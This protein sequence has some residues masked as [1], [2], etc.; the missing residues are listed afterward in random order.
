MADRGL[1]HAQFQSRPSE[2][3]VPGGGFERPQSI[4]GQVGLGHSDGL[5]FLMAQARIT[6]L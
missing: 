1:R 2:A 3:E 6:R 4:Q 5:V